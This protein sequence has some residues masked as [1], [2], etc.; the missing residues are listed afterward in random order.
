MD[1]TNPSFSLLEAARIV[2][3]SPELDTKL[4][5]L[6]GHVLSATGATAAVIYLLDPVANVLV[7]AA[8]AGM[9]GKM[10]TAHAEVSVDDPAE[11]VAKV[12]RDRRQ[13][14]VSGEEAASAFTGHDINWHS[15]VAV[16]L[17]AAD[18]AGGEDAE[19]V[20]LAA[21][22]E[23]SP[24][25]W[26]DMLTALADLSA[27]S[28][29]QARLQRALLE[30]ADWIGRLASTDPLTG[31]ANR[32]TFERMLELELAR[33][34]RQES[35]LSVLLFDV[36][37]FAEINTDAGSPAGDEVLRHVAATLADQVRLVD[38]VARYGHDEFAL[39]APGGGGEVVGRRVRDALL[40]REAAG[41]PISVS[42]GA[43][44][45][46][47]DGATT[48]ELLIAAGEA[49]AEAKRRGRGSIFVS[50]GA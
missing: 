43:V 10:V 49:L 50:S 2:A 20:L 1:R 31:L 26:D 29:R 6:A 45:Y 7:P 8:Q 23:A 21:Y 37:G 34:T 42:V 28:I 14:T 47:L 11:L 24:E 36:D 17:V 27:I 4:D 33:A 12:V 5:A 15:L 46:P 30:R 38:T 13:I 39:I 9:R 40:K 35:Q 16:P 25:G 32:I 3:R 22:E 18:E 41:K 19:G 44:V 48:S